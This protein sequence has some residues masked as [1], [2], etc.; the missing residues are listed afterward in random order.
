[1]PRYFF[2]IKDKAGTIRDREGIELDDLY[3]VQ[4]EATEGARQIMS[5]QVRKGHEPDGREFVVTD[6][7][8]GTVLTFP[9][10]LAIRD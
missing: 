6:E 5:E 8:G 3:A 2:H 7:Q 9:F 4:E 1:M 10:K